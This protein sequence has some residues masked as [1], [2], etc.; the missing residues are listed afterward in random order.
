MK[1]KILYNLSMESDGYWRFQ[2]WTSVCGDDDDPN[3]FVHQRIPEAPHS[4]VA[5]RFVDIAS[6]HDMA[7]YPPDAPVGDMLYFR[8]KSAD[9]KIRDSSALQAALKSIPES[10]SRLVADKEALS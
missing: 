1:L 6:V 8:K 7:E 4:N 2:A 10:L 9:I 3:V 5:E